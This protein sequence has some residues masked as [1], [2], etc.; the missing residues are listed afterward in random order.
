MF[1][2]RLYRSLFRWV[3]R[4]PAVP[5]GTEAVGYSRAVTPVMSLWIFASAVEMLVLHLLVP[6]PMVRIVLLVLSAWGLVWMLGFLASLKV[7]PHLISESG[8]RIRHGASVDIAVPWNVI[9]RVAVQ[10]RDLPSS[11]RTLQPRQ[12]ERGTDLQ[13]G[14][15]GE[16]N[17]HAV[18][19]RQLDVPTP[20]RV[21]HVTEL[22]FLVDDPDTYVARAREQLAREAAKSDQSR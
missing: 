19:D 17:V 14:V 16:V 13:V 7:Y 3:T 8:M 6:W 5:A 4:W 18:L 9:A 21:H 10:R 22:S 11:I 15:S 12:T 1:E 2:L 20:K